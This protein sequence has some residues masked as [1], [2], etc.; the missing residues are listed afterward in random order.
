MINLIPKEEKKKMT[1]DFYY[2]LLALFFM[3]MSFSVLVASIGMLPAYFFSLMKDATSNTKLEMQKN[4]QIPALDEQSLA[5]I[6]DMNTKLDLVESAEKNKFS[7]SENIINEILSDKTSDIKIVQIL[8]QN[9]AITGKTVV[10]LGTAPSRQALLT[11]EEALQ[12]NPAFKNINLPIS[13]FVKESN[14]QFNLTLMP[15]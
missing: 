2:R 10:I 12:N 1:S 13:N 9:D 6:Q 4:S 14:L 5:A 8:Y 15:S 11:F 7:V 3:M